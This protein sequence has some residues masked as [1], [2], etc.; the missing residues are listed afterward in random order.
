VLRTARMP[1]SLERVDVVVRPAA[2]VGQHGLGALGETTG[3]E[4]VPPAG[5]DPSAAAGGRD[6]AQTTPAERHLL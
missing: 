2:S 6:R 4:L 1:R 5:K 3:K